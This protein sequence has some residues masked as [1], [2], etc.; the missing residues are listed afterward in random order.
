MTTPADPTRVA[1]IRIGNQINE[2]QNANGI[3][4]GNADVPDPAA[5]S[6]SME[7]VSKD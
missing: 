7:A 4:A 6:V 5:D 2:T 1:K 3:L